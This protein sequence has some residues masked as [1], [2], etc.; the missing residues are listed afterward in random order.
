MR[1]IIIDAD[2]QGRESL[3]HSVKAHP[4]LEWIGTFDSCLKAHDLVVSDSIELILMDVDLPDVHGLAFLRHL[5]NP[6]LVVLLTA[7]HDYAVESYELNVVD[8]VLKPYTTAR[9]LQAIEKVFRLVKEQNMPHKRF[10]FFKKNSHFIK[11]E[12]DKILYLK[13]M[14]NYTQIVTAERNY[15]I[16]GRLAT[17]EKQLPPSLFLRTNRSCLVNMS[18]ITAINKAEILIYTHSINLTRAFAE[19]IF[20]SYINVHLIGKEP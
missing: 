7:N 17:I 16:L 14:E 20:N 3:T 8:Y 6:P 5:V 2:V 1:T 4:R 13:A 10:F 15:T 9:F 11:I 19:A 12:M 18:K